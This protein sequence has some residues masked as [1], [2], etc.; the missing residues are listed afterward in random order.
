MSDQKKP[1]DIK[2]LKARLGRTIAPGTQKAP[3]APPGGGAIPPPP[4]GGPPAGAGGVAPPP[5]MSPMGGP[6]PI[7]G[8]Q[9]APPPFAQPAPAPAPAPRDPFAAQKASQSVHP[10]EV[11]L[12]I[13]EKPV[14]DAEVGRKARGRIF[15]V[16]A[17]VLAVGMVMGYG[18]GSM[19]STR[20]LYNMAVRDGKDVNQVVNQ[21]SDTV[22]KAKRLVDTA[23]QNAAPRGAGR[24]PAVDYAT[25]AALRA[26]K[27][28]LNADA[29]ARKNY[30][31]FNPTTVDSLFVYY[32][33]INMA[34]DKFAT[35]AAR[36]LPERNHAELDR[37]A[38]A[39]GE[40]VSTQYGLVPFSNEGL[41]G[42]G[43]V[44]V[45]VPPAPPPPA[46]GQ[47]PAPPPTKVSVSD[48]PGGTPF[49]RTIYAGQDLNTTPS[50]YVILIDG[51]RSGGVLG[52][53][54]SPF[55]DYVRQIRE[56]QDLMQ[57]TV[58]TQGQLT[59]SL[60]EIARLE[61]QFAM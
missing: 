35:L 38:T 41:F 60:S 8:P 14:D 22:N 55:L 10:R 33:N 34:W 21:A 59:T 17:I 32:N 31:I 4:M 9:V 51:S 15:I 28:P 1:R 43:L 16:A 36:V 47:E 40:T 25:I 30:S 3:V 27:K 44:Y 53:R 39:A 11:H 57:K 20:K 18:A 42:G 61:E 45:T 2:D 58:E 29:F 7:L 54:A 5:M 23:M 12:V 46:P 6:S 13:D 19:M 52:Q 26:L 49:E 24:H 56:L 50:N 48:R 37:A